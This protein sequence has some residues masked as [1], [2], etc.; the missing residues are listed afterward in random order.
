MKRSN[1]DALTGGALNRLTTLAD[2]AI[3]AGRVALPHFRVDT[4]VHWKADQ[5]P[6]TAAD[7]DAHHV[8]SK[9]LT[10]LDP[11][12]PIVSEEMPAAEL[13]AFAQRPAHYW[14][15]DP[16]DGTRDFI[17]GSPDFT[18]NLAE[19]R[20]DIPQCSVIHAPAHG[21]TFAALRGFGAWE[22]TAAGQWQ[23]LQAHHQATRKPL[24]LVSRRDTDTAL[25]ALAQAVPNIGTQSVGSSLKF[26][27]VAAGEADLYLRPGPTMEWDTAAGHLILQESGGAVV[28]ESGLELTYGRPDFCNPNFAALSPAFIPASAAILSYIKRP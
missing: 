8:A 25:Q 10:R 1:P 20:Q 4:D 28:S 23:R 22:L 3:S 27:L 14:L 15:I 11:K 2:I 26:C 5:S 7:L 19:M 16:L 9:E 18:V 17:R 24:C 12:V 6:V 21:R 13:A